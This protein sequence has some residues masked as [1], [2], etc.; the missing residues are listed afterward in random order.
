MQCKLSDTLV[1]PVLI[2]SHAVWA[3][4]LCVG[5]AAELLQRGFLRQLLTTYIYLC[6]CWSTR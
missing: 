1:L 2:M 3:V 5:E 6:N 4:D